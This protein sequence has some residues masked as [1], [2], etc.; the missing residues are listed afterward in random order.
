[1]K[2][3]KDLSAATLYEHLAEEATELAHACLKYA[4]ALRG[5]NPVSFDV[6]KVYNNIEEELSDILNVAEVLNRHPNE[7]IRKMKM[8]RWIE[9]LNQQLKVLNK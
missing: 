7:E 3:P 5:E 4:R 1:M 8:Q 2:E 6:G 9:R